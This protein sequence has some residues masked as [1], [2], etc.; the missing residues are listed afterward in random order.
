MLTP[1][2]IAH[3][4]WHKPRHLNKGMASRMTEVDFGEFGL[5]SLGHGWISSRQIEAVR[6]V[7]TRYTKKGGQIWI[8][9]FP[10]RPV[11]R[12]AAETPMGKG[13]GT[14]EF[15]VATVKPGTVMF[16][17]GGVSEADARE[18]LSLGAYKLAMK[19]KV[20]SRNSK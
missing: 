10:D 13:K 16:E 2:K 18:A 17:M 15:Y 20:L 8:R 7:L 4:K 19:S 3:R 12:K 6:R 11:T 14:P 1:K 5:V 9:I